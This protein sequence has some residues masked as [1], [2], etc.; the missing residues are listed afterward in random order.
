MFR[1][2]CT[3]IAVG[4]SSPAYS[5]TLEQSVAY[6]IDNNPKI[7][8]QY[9]RFQAALRDSDVAAADYYPQV[10]ASAGVGYED[11]EY[12]TGNLIDHYT[13]DREEGRIT[14]SQLLFNGFKT[15]SEVARLSDEAESERLLLISEAEDLA[16]SVT[17]AYIQLDQS[18]QMVLLAERNLQEHEKIALDVQKKVNKGVS[19]RA[20]LAQIS[21]RLSSSQSAL[22]NARRQFIDLQ[23]QFYRIVGFQPSNLKTPVIDNKLFPEGLDEA[24]KQALKQHPQLKAAAADINA[25]NHEIKA[26]NSGFYPKISIDADLYHN[27]N[28]SG[29]DGHDNG[30]K[31]MLNMR[32]ELFSGFRTV[33]RSKASHWRYEEANAIKDEATRQVVETTKLSWNAANFLRQQEEVLK[34]NVDSA[35]LTDDGYRKQFDLGRRSLLDVLDAKVE[36]Y[37]ARKNY[38][39]VQYDRRMAEFRLANALGILTYALRI[40]YPE[41]WKT[42]Q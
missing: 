7:M 30:S 32:Y 17:E 6:A 19:S 11:I 22:L 42:E 4:L 23:T 34:A 26:S 9:S 31:I 36:V 15:S 38:L 39:T 13:K 28:I 10:F 20:D 25:V 2:L 8:R 35:V 24:L 12:K 18:E 3:I 1:L 37:L 27:D 21:S 14:V 41:Q 33:N 5:L 29:F 16:L 40:D